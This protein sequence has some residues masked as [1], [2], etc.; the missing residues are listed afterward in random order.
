MSKHHE[1]AS[2]G[3]QD[4]RRHKFDHQTR[5][6]WLHKDAGL[7]DMWRASGMT[8][9]EFIQHHEDEIDKVIIAKLGGD[10]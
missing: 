10:R 1:N 2:Y 6:E 8:R 5:S 4:A 9:D 7:Q 3:S